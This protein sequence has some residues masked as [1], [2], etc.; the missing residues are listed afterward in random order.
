MAH[1]KPPRI[2]RVGDGVI[3]TH[4]VR[5]PILDLKLFPTL[6]L[7]DSIE[8]AMKLAEKRDYKAAEGILRPMI[9]KDENDT[10]ATI[11]LARVFQK[12]GCDSEHPFGDPMGKLRESNRL[13]E[14]AIKLLQSKRGREDEPIISRISAHLR[15][16]NDARLKLV[17]ELFPILKPEGTVKKAMTAAINGNYRG[18]EVILKEMAQLNEQDQTPNLAL[19]IVLQMWGDDQNHPHG[20]VAKKYILSNGLFGKVYALYEG[21][22]SVETK[23][24]ITTSLEQ[25]F[26][27]LNRLFGHD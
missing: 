20:E 21:P 19:A 16:N 13:F 24:Q 7:I 11:A 5:Q 18:A 23:Q 1:P 8:D 4:I 12:W 10:S 6:K 3:D 2:S 14:K 25:N 17:F 22:K 26:R 27:S 9:L 15:Q